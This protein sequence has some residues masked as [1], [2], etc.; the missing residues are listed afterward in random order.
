[1]SGSGDLQSL[2]TI[3]YAISYLTSC[4]FRTSTN[5]GVVSRSLT[6][7]SGLME[8]CNFA[9]GLLFLGGGRCC[10]S[11]KHHSTSSSGNNNNNQKRESNNNIGVECEGISCLVLSTLPLYSPQP[12]LP[13]HSYFPMLRFL[14]MRTIEWRGLVCRSSSLS[15]SLTEN[16]EDCAET[17][18]LKVE[19]LNE[20]GPHIEVTTP[21][22]LP[23]IHK[24]RSI[25]I[26]DDNF[27]PQKIVLNNQSSLGETTTTTSLWNSSYPLS[28]IYVKRRTSTHHPILSCDFLISPTTRNTYSKL[29][30][31]VNH[32]YSILLHTPQEELLSKN[33]HHQNLINIHQTFQDL[34]HCWLEKEEEET[35]DHEIDVEKHRLKIEFEVIFDQIIKV[36][37]A[38]TNLTFNPSQEENSEKE[39]D[40]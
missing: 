37:Q 33:Y 24:I 8:G 1:M 9:L 5:K 3:K 23:P 28:P 4:S 20:F 13:N 11:T 7:V 29:L 35:F 36:Y 18:Q 15:S 31:C 25:E 30:N 32:F 34:F 6:N 39:E 16:E 19:F 2:Q 22:L 17:V 26:V 12:N 21:C 40:G 27:F 10:I 14:F 38:K